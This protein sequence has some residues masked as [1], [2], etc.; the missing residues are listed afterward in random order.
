MCSIGFYLDIID[1]TTQHCQACPYYCPDC[2]L[3][4]GDV[5]CN[6]CPTDSRRTLDAGM[7]ACNVG[8]FD[9]NRTVV[10]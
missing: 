3:V 4:A 7:C 2:S 8:F 10:C 6:S 1:A 5:V 9:D